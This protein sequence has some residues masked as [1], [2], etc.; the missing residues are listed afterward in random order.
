MKKLLAYTREAKE[1]IIYS[2]KLAASLHLALEIDGKFRP[3]NNNYGILFAK[4]TENADGSINAK[5]L[6]SPSVF[7]RADGG[8]G[9]VAVPLR[10]DWNENF[11]DEERKGSIIVFTTPDLV[12]YKETGALKLSDSYIEA[13]VCEAADNGDGYII[14]Y[15]DENGEFSA[16]TVDFVTIKNVKPAKMPEAPVVETD[17]EGAIPHGVIEITDEEADY[18]YKKLTVPYNIAIDVPEKI[19]VKSREELHALRVTARYSDGTTAKKRIDWYDDD[20]DFTVPGTYKIKGRVHQERFEFPFAWHRADPC[21]FKWKGKYYFIATNDRDG[22]NSISIRRADTI[23]GLTTA[24]ETKILD[25]TMYPHMKGLLW[26]PEFHVIKDKL[27][28][29]H[30]ATKDVFHN[31][32][33][34]VMK[35]RD[36]GNPMI[37]EDWEM[38]R[39]VEKADGTQLF[40]KGI[41]LD[42][43][44][45]EVD[46]HYYAVWSQRRYDPYDFGAWLYLAELNP[47][48]PW[49]LITEPVV[50]SK[51]DYGWAN[52]CT[53]VDEGPFAILTDKKIILTYSAAATNETYVVAMLTA[54]Y[55]S[56]LH[57]PKS[58]TKINYPLMSS[59]TRRGEYGPGHN[60]YVI[61]DEGDIW[62]FYHARPGINM[63]RSSGIRRV[64]FDIDGDPVLGLTEERD[65]SPSLA[66]VEIEVTVEA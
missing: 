20:I 18:L 25:T 23:A 4:A 55:G 37:P 58:W 6:A 39:L 12:H 49:K 41:T 51:P 46:G 24:Q 57:D 31:E 40:T 64:H 66:A 45:F 10:A 27:Y 35:L 19:T 26:A 3:L 61:D 17:I 47:D 13:V 59:Y 38:S 30:A 16:E 36:G 60:S 48:E 56:D 2:A 32:Q 9:V 50:I 11:P 8:F 53:F 65:L 63:P 42:M 62:N 1:Q 7:R 21:A 15:R 43:T 28:I 34:H 52:N 33:C 22:N 44:V 5:S 14:Y 54:E 29:F